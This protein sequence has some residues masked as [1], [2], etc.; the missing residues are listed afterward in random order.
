MA[1]FRRLRQSG[2]LL[3]CKR[4]ILGNL[5]SGVG[6]SRQPGFHLRYPSGVAGFKIASGRGLPIPFAV[7]V[8]SKSNAP[9]ALR[10]LLRQPQ[11]SGVIA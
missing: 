4:P 10:P 11:P 5:P 7:V 3:H 2:L 6:C 8:R 1:S 9:A